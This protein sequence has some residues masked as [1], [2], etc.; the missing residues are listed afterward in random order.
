MNL[1]EK[2]LLPL[3]EGEGAGSGGAASPGGQGGP[4]SAG[5]AAAPW[6]Q[7]IDPLIIGH[8]Q[9]KGYDL[10]DPGKV[11]LEAT[12]QARELERHFGVPADQLIKLPKDTADEA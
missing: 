1:L 3:H 10:A 5:A 8:W 11:A 2:Y 9:N 6:H 7:G 4:G 12:K